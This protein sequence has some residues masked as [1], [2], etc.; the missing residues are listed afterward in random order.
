M[1]RGGLRKKKVQQTRPSMFFIIALSIAIAL[2]LWGA[3]AVVQ[4]PVR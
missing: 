3:G 2:L 1:S 4:Q